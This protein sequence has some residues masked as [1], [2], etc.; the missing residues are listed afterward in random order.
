MKPESLDVKNQHRKIGDD[1][2]KRVAD[3]GQVHFHV[4]GHSRKVSEFAIKLSRRLGLSEQQVELVQKG[5]LLHDIGK[6][7]LPKS[8]LSKP[9]KLTSEEYEIIKI[10]P[11]F[12]A[13]LLQNCPKLRPLVP[14]VLHHHEFFNG[15]GYPDRIIGDQIALETRIISVSDAVDAMSSDRPYR[16]A[17]STKQIIAELKKNSGTQFDPLIVAAA[18]QILKELETANA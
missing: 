9:S 6:M 4:A 10:H 8:L 7:C 12:G 16:R 11:L 5:S 3:I 17:L 15:Q 1:L 13:T 2:Q 18:I 14:I